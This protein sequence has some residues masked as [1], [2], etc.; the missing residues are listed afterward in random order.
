MLNTILQ[1]MN[2]YVQ[3]QP[4]N[5][6]TE[7]QSRGMKQEF[8]T[9]T[10][11]IRTSLPIFSLSTANHD[12]D[13]A[14]LGCRSSTNGLLCV[15]GLLLV[16][17][18]DQGLRGNPGFVCGATFEGHRLLLIHSSPP[19]IPTYQS[20]GFHTATWQTR[21]V[22]P[23]SR[24]I[25]QTPPSHVTSIYRNPFADIAISDGSIPRLIKGGFHPQIGR[26]HV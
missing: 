8:I 19:S 4:V 15:V 13:V 26:A 3:Y 5:I 21:Y 23:H 24:F 14:I 25:Q 2:A 18:S 12:I 20:F 16:Q 22:L 1:F 6:L 7:P 9:T 10:F 11:G 17:M